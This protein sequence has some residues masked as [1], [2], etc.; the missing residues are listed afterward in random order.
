MTT[1]DVCLVHDTIAGKEGRKD[2]MRFES[3]VRIETGTSA[4]VAV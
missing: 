4:L 2:V 1:V 3:L